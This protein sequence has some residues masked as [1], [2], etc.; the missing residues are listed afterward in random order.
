MQTHN[1]H[2]SINRTPTPY[3][4]RML[5]DAITAIRASYAQLIVQITARRI[6]QIILHPGGFI[7]NKWPTDVEASITAI[8]ELCEADVRSFLKTKG[9]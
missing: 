8:N 2:I 6:P 9:F 1:T 5:S 7:K 3:E 4:Q